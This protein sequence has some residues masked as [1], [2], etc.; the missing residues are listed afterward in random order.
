MGKK[1][2]ARLT[3]AFLLKSKQ[4]G[5]PDMASRFIGGFVVKKETESGEEREVRSGIKVRATHWS[6]PF[7]EDDIDMDE[8][9]EFEEQGFIELR[10]VKKKPGRPPKKPPEIKEEE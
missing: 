5:K 7:D 3:N 1:Y 6:A 9:R 4:D 10:H 8:F 2:E